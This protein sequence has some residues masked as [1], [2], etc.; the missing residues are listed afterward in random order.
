[1]SKAVRFENEP[2]NKFRALADAI[3]ENTQRE[4]AVVTEK[5]GYA[6]Y[7]A[8]LPEGITPDTIKAVSKY[9]TTFLKA[10]TIA[11]GEIAAEALLED[12]SLTSVTATIGFQAPGDALKFSVDRSR[13][14]PVPRKAGEPADAPQKRVTKHL[15]IERTVEISGQSIKSVSSVMSEEFKDRFAS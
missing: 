3:R 12:K 13:E 5:E 4:G 14:F 1:M 9:N 10:S 11:V 6:A 15:H 7:N 8:N 2:I